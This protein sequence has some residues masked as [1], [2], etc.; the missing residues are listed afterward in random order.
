[1]GLSRLASA[2]QAGGSGGESPLSLS[3]AV[4]STCMRLSASSRPARSASA[5]VSFAHSLARARVRKVVVG[6]H[7][8]PKLS[9]PETFTACQ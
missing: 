1:M 5:S 2:A 9:S 6:R 4:V 3:F 8:Y 7:D